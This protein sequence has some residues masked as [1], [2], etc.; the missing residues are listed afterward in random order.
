MPDLPGSPRKDPFH[1]IVTNDGL[2]YSRS[3][4]A[5]NILKEARLIAASIADPICRYESYEYVSALVA[6]IGFLNA[7]RYKTHAACDTTLSS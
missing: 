3:P 5:E 4:I 2:T 1:E 6:V 7:L